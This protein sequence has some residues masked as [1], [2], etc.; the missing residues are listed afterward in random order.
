MIDCLSPL[1]LKHLNETLALKTG[2]KSIISS[3]IYA[4]R[5]MNASIRSGGCGHLKTGKAPSEM[6]TINSMSPKH[7]N[8]WVGFMERISCECWKLEGLKNFWHRNRNDYSSS[9]RLPHDPPTAGLS[10]GV[11]NSQSRSAT[12]L[13][14]IIEL[15]E[16]SI[17]KAPPKMQSSPVV[18]YPKASDNASPTSTTSLKAGIVSSA[19]TFSSPTRP[20]TEEDF[21][22]SKRKFEPSYEANIESFF[23][24]IYVGEA[25]KMG[26]PGR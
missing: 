2:W 18:E 22:A 23:H 19:D 1:T 21:L 10:K 15:K 13:P 14:P 4:R 8:L 5:N 12:A 20:L 26:R 7:P 16:L 17:D 6:A 25:R 11:A 3:R 24:D 9:E